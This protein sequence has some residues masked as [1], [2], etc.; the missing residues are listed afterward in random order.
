[1]WT[2]C[3]LQAEFEKVAA[4]VKNLK[5]RP[6]DEELL[7]LYGL[8]KQAV[9]GDVNIGMTCWKKS[10]IT[11]IKCALDSEHFL[12]SVC[13]HNVDKPGMT[14]LKGKAKWDAW[15]SRKGNKE[16][17]KMVVA[18]KWTDSTACHFS[19]SCELQNVLIL[20]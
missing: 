18:L 12:F 15:N 3:H 16:K 20:L 19:I 11:T 2:V 1:M 9:A 13:C 10:R 5:K 17:D 8:Y 6:T 14:D 4:D 7:H